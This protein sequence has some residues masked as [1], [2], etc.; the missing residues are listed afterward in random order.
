MV[1]RLSTYTLLLTN[2]DGRWEVTDLLPAP[3]LSQD[4]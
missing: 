2:R 1:P 4:D 3:P